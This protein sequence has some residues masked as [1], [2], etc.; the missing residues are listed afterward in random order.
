MKRTSLLILVSCFFVNALTAQI[1]GTGTFADPY[2][3]IGSGDFAIVGTKYFD[4]NFG[5]SAGTLTLMPY[6]RLI[7]KSRYASIVISGTGRISAIGTATRRIL[8]TGDTDGD[9]IAGESSDLWGNILLTSSGT[10]NFSYVTVENGRR[11]RFSFTGGAMHIGSGT[12]NI[13]NSNI[14]NSSARKGG[15]IYLEAGATVTISN[16]VISGNNATENGGAIYMAAGSA[17][18]ITSTVFYDNSASSVLLKGGAIASI[19]SSPVIVN[20]T[21]VSNTS[22]AG[23]GAGIYL[24]DSPG[25][26]GCQLHILG[27]FV[28]NSP[29][30]NPFD[31]LRYLRHRGEYIRGL[32]DTQQQQHGCRRTKF[33]GSVHR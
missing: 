16:C 25:G 11:T 12:V 28:T 1:T 3:G 4:N 23:D 2:R 6:S 13:S 30:R 31:S 26:K 17:P 20:S 9:M 7:C 10:S 24:E 33:H 18:V 14:R 21:F 32:P 15:G 27:R 19:S 5:V 8:I 22:M 29:L